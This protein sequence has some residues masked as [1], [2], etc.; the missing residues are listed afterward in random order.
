MVRQKVWKSYFQSQ[1]S[2]SK[3]NGIFSKK[4]HF[5]ISIKETIF[6]KKKTF[7]SNFNFEPLYFLKS[8]PIFD[9]LAL[10]VFS[11]YNGFL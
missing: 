2:M 4:N 9:E 11:K 5:R 8:C 10:P 1:F 7:F 6:C 3:I